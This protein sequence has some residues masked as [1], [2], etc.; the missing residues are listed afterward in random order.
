MDSIKDLQD[1]ARSK[2]AM[3]SAWVCNGKRT[4]NEKNIGIVYF[5]LGLWNDSLRCFKYLAPLNNDD[6]DLTFY[7]SM[8][9]AWTGDHNRAIELRQEIS[10]DYDRNAAIRIAYKHKGDLESL[11]KL[12]ELELANKIYPKHHLLW[13]ALQS[14]SEAYSAKGDYDGE[15]KML[16]RAVSGVGRCRFDWWIWQFLHEAY[17]AK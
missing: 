2:F 13:M 8:A 16:E 7:K 9:F 6:N 11:E 17:Q 14:L 3:I 4:L 1:I 15:I 12:F 10:D 5:H